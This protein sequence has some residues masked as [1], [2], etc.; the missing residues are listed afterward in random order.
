MTRRR[1]PYG[2]SMQE[3]GSRNPEWVLKTRNPVRAGDLRCIVRCSRNSL[4]SSLGAPLALATR[5]TGPEASGRLPSRNSRNASRFQKAFQRDGNVEPLYWY[6]T[7]KNDGPCLTL[8][9]CQ[10]VAVRA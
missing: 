6:H 3:R 2:I 10:I 4:P 5:S 8:R 9:R 1:L 7:D